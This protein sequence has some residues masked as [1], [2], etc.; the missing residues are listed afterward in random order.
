M[1][2]PTPAISTFWVTLPVTKSKIECRGFLVKE[3]K[4]L[5]QAVEDSAIDSMLLAMNNVLTACTFDKIDILKLPSTDVEW[6]MLQIRINSVGETVEPTID[7]KCGFRIPLR[8]NLKEVQ[9]TFPASE[10]SKTNIIDLG[11]GVSVE[12][13]YPTFNSAINK[14]TSALEGEQISSNQLLFDTVC[15]CLIGVYDTEQKYETKDSTPLEIREFVES[16]TQAQFEKIV[17]FFEGIPYITHSVEWKCPQCSTEGKITFEGV[18]DF[19]V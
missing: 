7:C 13:Q 8:I 4:I 2:L 1:K 18:S 19:F 9:A 17:R 12:L 14:L 11:C 10:S 5:L 16:L 15:D 6:L 3:E